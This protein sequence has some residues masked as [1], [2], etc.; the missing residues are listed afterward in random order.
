MS[1]RGE[2]YRNKYGRG[3]GGRGRGNGYPRVYHQ[4]EMTEN[5]NVESVVPSVGHLNAAELTWQRLGNTLIGIDKRNYGS[6]HALER[7]FTFSQSTLSFKLAF[8]F[9][10]GDPY[11]SPS[12][13]HVVVHPASAGF[14]A[15]MYTSK[16]RNIALCDYLTRQ[17]ARAARNSGADAKTRM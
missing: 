3:R 5:R 1:S 15:E 17:F 9:I 13:A 8:D 12:R 6:Y 14:P 7:V 10:Q 11:A 2:Y 4:D 16:I